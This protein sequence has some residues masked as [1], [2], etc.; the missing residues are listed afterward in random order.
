MHVYALYTELRM[1]L[2]IDAWYIPELLTLATILVNYANLSN[3]FAIPRGR[4]RRRQNGVAYPYM[5][6]HNTP[7]SRRL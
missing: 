5:H 2:E 4:Q 6:G 1:S 7:F 3:P